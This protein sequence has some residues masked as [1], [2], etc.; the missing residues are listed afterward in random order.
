MDQLQHP[1]KQCYLACF[2]P[3]ILEA[4]PRSLEK[5]G[6]F[7]WN[8]ETV[9]YFRVPANSDMPTLAVVD[10]QTTGFQGLRCALDS[11]CVRL[12]YHLELGSGAG[13]PLVESPLGS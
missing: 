8:K 6:Q 1:R 11:K 3:P 12:C 2:P 13:M 7:L 9:N 5:G 4:E 10:P